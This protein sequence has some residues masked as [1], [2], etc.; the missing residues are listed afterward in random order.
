[1]VVLSGLAS[2]QEPA[3]E[4]L[5]QAPIVAGDRVRAR[6]RALDEALRQAVE[7]AAGTV[8]SPDELVGRASDLKLRVYPKAKQYVST[9]RILDEG[10]A[11][12]GTFQVHLSAQVATGKLARDLAT[13]SGMTGLPRLPTRLRAVV[14]AQ[15]GDVASAGAADKAIKDVLAARNVE[16]IA[17]PNCSDNDAAQAARQSGAQGAVTAL[18]DAKPEGLIR[19]TDKQGA[20]ARTRVHVLEPDGRVSADADT[21]KDAYGD[22]E[23][24][25]LA[26]AAREAVADA[27]L[28]L[29]PALGQKWS[30]AAPTSGVQVR[31]SG[32]Q[33]Y[34]DYQLVVRALQA[35]PGVAAVEPRRFAKG[36]AD[37]LV[38]TASGAGQLAAGLNRVPPQGV[39]VNVRAAGNDLLQID[40]TSPSEGAVPERG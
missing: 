37:L 12:P 9:Y 28:R 25:A 32:I 38:K 27:L 21:E 15:S 8:L 39:R 3:F 1:M 6:E 33:H 14:C 13:T 31:L 22:A 36:Q 4:A 18:V 7:Q 29:Q 30:Q 40:V 35:L 2:A 20:H 10:E 17:P 26:D 11:T 5:G 19:G 23:A 34:A 16:A 24:R